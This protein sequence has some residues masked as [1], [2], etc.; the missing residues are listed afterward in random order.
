MK[1]PKKLKWVI[2]ISIVAT[3]ILT[4][5]LYIF[6][7]KDTDEALPS[8]AQ[9]VSG[10]VPVDTLESFKYTE[11]EIREMIIELAKKRF[12]E[13]AYVIPLNADSP[14]QAEIEGKTRYIYIYA[15]DSL[16]KQEDVDD[17][18]GL[19]HVDPVTGEI[20]DNGNGKMEKVQLED[21]LNEE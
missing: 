11:A 19:Y 18:K 21:D 16:S 3:I 13:D 6:I 17:I 4:F 2:I 15:A 8:S 20:F 14:S 12:G 5:F 9:P 7:N 1:N 10:S